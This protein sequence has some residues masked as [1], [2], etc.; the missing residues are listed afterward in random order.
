MKEADLMRLL[1]V[2]ASKLGARLFRNN[3]GT[4]LVVRGSSPQHREAIL[5]ACQATAERLGG[6]AAR[7]NFGLVEG[8]GDCIGWRPRVITQADVGTTIAQFASAEVKTAKGRSSPTQVRWRDAVNSAGG[9][10]T[11]VRS[12]EDMAQF[13]RS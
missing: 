2:E 3:V 6:S 1:M 9:A 13:L 7:I 8:S 4:G 11:E 12:V 5:K 10:A